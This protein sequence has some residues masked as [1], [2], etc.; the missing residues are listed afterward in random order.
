[1][2]HAVFGFRT[3]ASSLQSGVARHA[4]GLVRPENALMRPGWPAAKNLLVDEAPGAGWP[5]RLDFVDDGWSTGAD[6]GA[7]DVSPNQPGASPTRVVVGED[8]TR[9]PEYPKRARKP[10]GL[11]RIERQLL[12]ADRVMAQELSKP[13][14]GNVTCPEFHRGAQPA[15]VESRAMQFVVTELQS[16]S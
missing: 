6:L 4:A 15:G 11:S 5:A 8:G 13:R 16:G 12:A 7:A 9:T 1:M 2:P 10:R 14:R 3:Y